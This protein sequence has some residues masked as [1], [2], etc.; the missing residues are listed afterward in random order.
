MEDGERQWF[1]VDPRGGLEWAQEYL[2][3]D[4]MEAA[5]KARRDGEF[6]A[7]MLEGKAAL[8]RDILS[9]ALASLPPDVS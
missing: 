1:E 2:V 3:A 5:A 4:L 7:T 9:N 8:L 6:Q